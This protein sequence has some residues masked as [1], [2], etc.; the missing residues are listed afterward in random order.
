[1]AAITWN[2]WGETKLDIGQVFYFMWGSARFRYSR[3]LWKVELKYK[4]QEKLKSTQMRGS[5]KSPWHVYYK[6]LCVNLKKN[7]CQNKQTSVSSHFLTILMLNL[8]K[9]LKVKDVCW[10]DKWHQQDDRIINPSLLLS[11]EQLF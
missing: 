7:L 1:M 3:S 6:C 8:S 10:N 4:L 11:T 5:S 2:A 9:I